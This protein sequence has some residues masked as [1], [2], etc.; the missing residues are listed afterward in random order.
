MHREADLF[1][2]E[3]NPFVS[4]LNDYSQ[5]LE[6]GKMARDVSSVF[7]SEKATAATTP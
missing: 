5:H 3:P 4:L 1:D 6:M 2:A 7:V